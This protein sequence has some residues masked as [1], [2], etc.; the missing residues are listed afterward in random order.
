MVHDNFTQSLINAKN[1]FIEK[2]NKYGVSNKSERTLDGIVFD[3]KLEMTRYAYLKILESRGIISN[4][5]RQF[6]FELIP[7]FTCQGIKYRSVSYKADFS[8]DNKKG[9][10]IIEDAKGRVTPEYRTKRAILLSAKH[11]FLFYEI[12]DA[13][14]IGGIVL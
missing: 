6:T 7:K 13:N 2:Q 3:S 1:K 5:Q 14:D 11:D 9:E 4:L 10:W 12:K 8:Y